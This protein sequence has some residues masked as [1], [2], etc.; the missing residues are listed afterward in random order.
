MFVW[1]SWNPSGGVA[2]DRL[3]VN[4]MGPS[5]LP[6]GANEKMLAGL[7]RCQSQRPPLAETTPPDPKPQ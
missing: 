2:W 6:A 7:R 1:M 5:K 4:V 3:F